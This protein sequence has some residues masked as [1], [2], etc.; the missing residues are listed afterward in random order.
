MACHHVVIADCLCLW[1]YQ[2]SFRNPN[3]Y[4]SRKK[5]CSTPPICTEVHPPV[6][7]LEQRETQQ[8]TSH[9]YC[10]AVLLPFVLENFSHLYGSTFEKVLRVGVTG[11]FLTSDSSEGASASSCRSARCPANLCAVSFRCFVV[12]PPDVGSAAWRPSPSTPRALGPQ[13]V[14]DIPAELPGYPM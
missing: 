11:K 1:T 8:Y 3:P 4:W 14:R 12:V 9:L 6:S 10:S 5:C 13:G 7:K 2:K